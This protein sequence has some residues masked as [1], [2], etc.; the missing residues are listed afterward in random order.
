MSAQ[1]PTD[2][3]PRQ[4]TERRP[5]G[6]TCA[7]GTPCKAWAV[8]GTDPPR[9]APHGGGSAPV[10]APPGNQNARTHG[11]YAHIASPGASPDEC[12][13]DNIIADLY[14][15]QRRVSR[16]IDENIDDLPPA[17]LA[18]FLRIHGQ[19]SSRLGRLLRDR[20]ILTG[21]FGDGLSAAIEQ[22]LVELSA[23]LGTDLT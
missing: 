12:T 20:D 6:A 9:C 1:T 18:R 11:F 22:A 19:N 15:K 13:I 4:R 10:G 3:Q 8:H 21:G 5:C 16:Y 14:C 17:D 23:E 2:C 7:D